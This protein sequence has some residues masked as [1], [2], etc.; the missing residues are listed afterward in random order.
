M[1]INLLMSSNFKY[2][3]ILL[4][5]MRLKISISLDE[6]MVDAI[7]SIREPLSRSAYIQVAIHEKLERDKSK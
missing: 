1:Y 7:D 4:T 5:T 2:N 3:D 6:K